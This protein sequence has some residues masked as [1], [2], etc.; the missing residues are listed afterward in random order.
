[1]PRCFPFWLPFWSHT[2]IMHQDKQGSEPASINRAGQ[3]APD[4]VPEPQSFWSHQI[5]CKW[6]CMWFPSVPESVCEA[7]GRGKGA[8]RGSGDTGKPICVM[9]ECW[10]FLSTSQHLEILAN[11]PVFKSLPRAEVSLSFQFC[12]DLQL[13]Y[14]IKHCKSCR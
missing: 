12:H 2:R 10:G 9:C 8:Q 7:I 14:L 5:K 6:L 11:S 13:V 4:P 1:M 3:G